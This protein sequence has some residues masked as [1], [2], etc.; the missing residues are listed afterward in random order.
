MRYCVSIL[1]V[2]MLAAA[3][4]SLMAQE[5]LTFEQHVR[6]ILKTYCL[7]CHGGGEKLEG[8]LDLRL[9]RFAVKGGDSGPAL[10]AGDATKSKLIERM[11]SGEM[12]PSEK[13]VPADQIAIIEK[14]IAAGAQAG[15][16]EPDK[17][18]PG[19]DI[20]PEERAFWSFQPIR[21]PEPPKLEPG[22][23]VIRTPIDNFILARL[24]E[25]GL[26]FS[27]EADK[28]MLIR[29]VALDLTGLPPS[30]PEIAAFVADNS[31]QAYEKMI[32]Q[33]LASPHYGERWAR[34]WLDV[35]GYADSEGNGNEDTVRPYLWRY[36]DYVIRSLNSD[37]PLNQFITE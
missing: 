26:K 20:T 13:K 6:P 17:L 19:I 8:N 36:R 10:V 24:R 37:K 3:A 16:A 15:R 30:E 21:R 5:K 29:R 4:S 1:C 35:A 14:W 18:P 11:K 33:Y 9:A 28:L 12:P 22:A 27:A 31:E 2:G 25:K 32:D 23:E 7:D 34:H